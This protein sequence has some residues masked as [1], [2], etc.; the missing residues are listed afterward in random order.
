V[1]S[2][3]AESFD[4]LFQVESV[5]LKNPL[6]KDLSHMRSSLIFGGLESIALNEKHRAN[7]L[8]LF[9][10]GK[11]YR[12]T[13][14]GYAEKRKL[15]IWMVGDQ[16]PESWNRTAEKNTL[17]QL[18]SKVEMVL[19]A[20]GVKQLEWNELE[21]K[22]AFAYG[23][24]AVSQKKVWGVC[25]QVRQ[26]LLDACD[27][28]QDVF[29]AEFEFNTLEKAASQQK[30]NFEPLTKYPWVRRD[31]SLLVNKPTSFETLRKTAFKA[32]RKLL[33]DVSLFDVYEGKN[34]P[35][36]KK[37][38][39]LK[40][41]LQDE[42]QTLTDEAVEKSMQRILQGLQTECSAELR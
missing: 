17:I 41:I 15:A 2:T 32:E 18:R 13:E 20:L 23:L 33:K 37:S 30:N 6:S 31:L 1:K 27:V 40:F 4:T 9:E 25:G 38:Y 39:A 42:Q 36:G 24:E 3:Y 7:N 35:E 11:E 26:E 12:K 29:Y 8:R 16:N 28:Q 10:I 14:N 34:L 5:S 22:G 21:E 19:N